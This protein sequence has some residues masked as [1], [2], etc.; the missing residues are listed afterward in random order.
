MKTMRWA[1][2]AAALLGPGS[3]AAELDIKG[4]RI[5]MTVEELQASHAGWR[6]DLP[7]SCYLGGPASA[8]LTFAGVQPASYTAMFRDGRLSFIGVLLRSDDYRIVTNALTEKY[9]KPSARSSG[10][11]QNTFGATLD[12]ETL[13]WQATGVELTA[14]KRGSQQA[15]DKASVTLT[16]T[17]TSPAAAARA[18]E[19]VRARAKDL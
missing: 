4:W 9:G 8:G 12:N 15:I 3:A 11:T 19:E 13:T 1:L 10:H 5:G 6:C 17:S 2:T 7:S 14:T 18:K 16:A